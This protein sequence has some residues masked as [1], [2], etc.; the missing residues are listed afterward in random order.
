[1][2]SNTPT[3]TN[4]LVANIFPRYDTPQ[5]GAGS[6]VGDQGQSS[7]VG[8]Q[9]QGQRLCRSTQHPRKYR[10][11]TEKWVQNMLARLQNIKQKLRLDVKCHQ[12]PGKQPQQFFYHQVHQSLGNIIKNTSCYFHHISYFIYYLIFSF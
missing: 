7:K 6:K 10:K 3:N 8:R 12:Q 1:M 11:E 9:K 5:V 4:S 2:C